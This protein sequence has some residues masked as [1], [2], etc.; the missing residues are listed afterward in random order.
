MNVESV[1][2]RLQKACR[3]QSSPRFWSGTTSPKPQRFKEDPGCRSPRTSNLI[4]ITLVTVEDTTGDHF[5]SCQNSKRTGVSVAWFCQVLQQARLTQEKK[6]TCA[7]TFF[8]YSESS[9]FAISTIKSYGIEESLL[10]NKP[11][12]GEPCR[13]EL[14]LKDTIFNIVIMKPEA[15]LKSFAIIRLS[16][17]LHR[18]KFPR[19]KKLISKYES[20]ELELDD[21]CQNLPLHGYKESDGHSYLH[22]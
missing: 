4:K 16:V 20:E 19:S 13:L 17:F 5:E 9:I 8:R 3:V 12:P 15:I 10:Y 21:F 22:T 6:S 7:S 1:I 14:L 18:I 2:Y 11:R